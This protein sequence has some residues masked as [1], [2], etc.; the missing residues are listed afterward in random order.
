MKALLAEIEDR[1]RAIFLQSFHESDWDAVFDEARFM[2][3]SVEALK[4]ELDCTWEELTALMRRD[5]A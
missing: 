1:R 2:G 4:A 3:A 5:D